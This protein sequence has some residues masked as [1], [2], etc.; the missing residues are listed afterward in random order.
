M[1]VMGI[2]LSKFHILL[3]YILKQIW[4]FWRILEKQKEIFKLK[5]TA[6]G[7]SAY[8]RSQGRQKYKT[9]GFHGD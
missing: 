6:E 5:W 3:I 8:V 4:Y 2:L 9:C 7:N 1:Q